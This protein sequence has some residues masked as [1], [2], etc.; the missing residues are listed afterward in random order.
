[1]P[2]RLNETT[3][4]FFTNM[5]KASPPDAAA[6]YR[7][8][9]DPTSPAGRSADDYLTEQEPGFASMLHL[10]GSFLVQRIALLFCGN[11]AASSAGPEERSGN[12]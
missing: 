1:V 2:V 12:G 4:A 11:R 5:A 3:R 7:A 6:R 10:C 9:L 8:I